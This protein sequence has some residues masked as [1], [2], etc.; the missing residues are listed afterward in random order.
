MSLHRLNMRNWLPFINRIHVRYNAFDD[1]SGALRE[2]VRQVQ[3]PKC[4]ASNPQCEVVQEIAEP[5]CTK[6]PMLSLAFVNDSTTSLDTATMQVDT[7]I[8]EVEATC[9][10]IE[11][12]LLAKGHPV[13]GQDGM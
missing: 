13:P 12:E 7:I 8:G 3:A 9:L 4:A 2:F 6:P 5:W 11:N 1:D 10:A